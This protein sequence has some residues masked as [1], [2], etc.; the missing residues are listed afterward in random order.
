MIRICPYDKLPEV[1]P[2]GIR[3]FKMAQEKFNPSPQSFLNFWHTYYTSGMGCLLIEEK[4]GEIKGFC[5]IIFN[6]EPWSGVLTC[7]EMCWYSEGR[8][9]GRLIKQALQ[10]AKK[11]GAKVFYAHSLN[12]EYAEK[13]AK[14]YKKEGLELSYFRYTKEL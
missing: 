5:G 1:L 12:N 7:T 6:N 2:L 9:G 11:A 13:V 10:M 4:G 8:E 3:F 14:F